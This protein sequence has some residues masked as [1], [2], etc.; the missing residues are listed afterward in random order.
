MKAFIVKAKRIKVVLLLLVVAVIVYT[1]Y[2]YTG[3]INRFVA[4]MRTGVDPVYRIKASD[5]V[6]AL[7]FD[8]VWGS[9]TTQEILDILDQHNVKATFFLTGKWIDSNRS[10]AKKILEKGH[11]VGNLTFNHPHVNNLNQ[12]QIRTE[13]EGFQGIFGSITEQRSLLFRPPFGEYNGQ[14]LQ[15]AEALGYTTV[16]WD[17]DSGDWKE[18]DPKKIEN[19]VL[20]KARKGSIVLFH[21]DGPQTHKALPTIIRGLIK[22]GYSIVTVSDLLKD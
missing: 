20:K 8:G 2:N 18:S 15:V 7:T 5:K 19:Q 16:L 4:V 11:E 17:V 6:V 12:M 21:L 22:N 3:G 13:L 10:I 14:V 1:G 9:D